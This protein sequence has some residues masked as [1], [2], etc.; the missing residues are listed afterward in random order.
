MKKKIL[1]NLLAVILSILPTFVNAA[2]EIDGI[3]YN[4]NTSN[5][6]AEVTN[7]S[8]LGV[9]KG[10]II[11]PES[12]QYNNEEYC[13]T[14]IGQNA[15]NNRTLL[16]SITIP[17]SVT[18]I[19][20][21]A[22]C[23]CHSLTS[24]VIPNSVISIGDGAFQM[25]GLTSITIPNSV[26]SIGV[27]LFYQ[28]SKLPSISVESG[29]PAYD[30]RENCN[31]IIETSS[32]TL[33][34]GCK[35]SVIPN[36]VTSIADYAFVGSGLM[37]ISIPNSVTSIG[38]YAFKDCS[39]LTSVTIG[40]SVTSIGDGAF[41][42]CSGL[43]SVNISDLAVW[44]NISFERS[45]SNPCYS[46]HHLYLN[47]T[48][49]KDLVIPNSVT[50]IGSYA[51]YGCSGLTSVTIP[52]SLTSI[53]S[54]AFSSCSRLTSVTIPSSMTSIGERAFYGCSGL[55]SVTIHNSVTTIG[56]Y[57]FYGCSS[58]AKIKTEN[59]TPLSIQ[60]STF[61]N[62]GKL[63]VPKGSR[64]SYA[65]ANYW[66]VF[67]IK[68][69]PNSDVNEDNIT[70][71]VDVVDIARFVVAISSASFE[72]FLADMNGDRY[73]NIADAI[74]LVNEI[75]GNTQFAKP[76]LAPRK[77]ASD[78]LALFGDGSNLSLEMEGNGDYAAF[79]FDLW[80]PADMDLMQVSLNDARRQGHQLL[81][82]KMGDGHYRVVALSTSGNV[83]NGTSGELLSMTLDDFATDD[84]RIDNIHFVTARG[85]D[86]PFEAIGVCNGN[87][88]VT[89]DIHSVDSN[90]T[91]KPVYNLNGQRLTAPR[92][93]LNIIGG[94]KIVVK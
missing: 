12:V 93:G 90:N 84:V 63:F 73:V 92:K 25:A 59:S 26:T 72:E 67:T 65:S 81:Y 31:A 38:K 61:S 77:L 16:S 15:F 39:G 51:F 70:D 21:G 64:S 27:N 76:A 4:L 69:Y 57:A 43:T 88:G 20:A 56:S 14:S 28:C 94:K 82:N 5:K 34:A 58:L 37:S 11:I 41:Y 17:N 6:T 66:K 33:I 22:F 47:G 10:D 29:N 87:N 86:V 3:Y 1:L 13:V 7:T 18:S 68:E 52:N 40:N 74:V 85:I 44:C 78:M 24:I 45:N 48:E 80:L 8:A 91:T 83:F 30:S 53:G 23:D 79:Q 35:S 46:A 50:S 75:A 71:V 36:S 62:Y 60:S 49:V 55:T 19:G 9:Y 42:G 54:Y 89:T 32:N 2:T